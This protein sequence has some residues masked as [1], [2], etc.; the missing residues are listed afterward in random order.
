MV[1]NQLVDFDGDSY[2]AEHIPTRAQAEDVRWGMGDSCCVCG[3]N[4][5][6]AALPE[7][8][9]VTCDEAWLA[10]DAEEGDYDG[11]DDEG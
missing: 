11:D 5:D 4:E 1:C 9:E 7:E 10:L 8:D 2:C 6:G 3:F